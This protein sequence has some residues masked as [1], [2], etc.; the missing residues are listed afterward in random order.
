MDAI[1]QLAVVK[2]G[3]SKVRGQDRRPMKKY[4]FTNSTGHT[5]TT[6]SQTGLSKKLPQLER[7]SKQQ[8]IHL[9]LD[10]RSPAINFQENTQTFMTFLIQFQMV[11][12]KNWNKNTWANVP[13][14]IQREVGFQAVQ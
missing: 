4:F 10:G 7:A 13:T 2:H 11:R 14:S 8:Q 5:G 3:I 1:E 9:A 12:Q 6:F